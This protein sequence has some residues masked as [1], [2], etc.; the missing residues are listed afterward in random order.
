[1]LNSDL[2]QWESAKLTAMLSIAVEA[3][4]NNTHDP[5][6]LEQ[7]LDAL[8]A[9]LDLAVCYHQRLTERINNDK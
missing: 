2:C 6:R 7:A 3:A 1:M 5:K 4:E 9:T 8:N